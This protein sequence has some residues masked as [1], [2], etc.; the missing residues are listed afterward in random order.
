MSKLLPLLTA[1]IFF[2]F[3]CSDDLGP[4]SNV[5]PTCACGQFLLLDRW[6]EP[7]I[8]ENKAYH[9]DSIKMLNDSEKWNLRVEDS[10]VFFNYGLLSSDE[11]YYIYLSSSV[12]DTITVNITNTPGECF[13]VKNISEFNYSGTRTTIDGNKVVVIEI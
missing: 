5:M 12:Q 2:T 7:L 3:S 9:P 8:G 1:L 13:T 4:C 6:G 10:L 11:E